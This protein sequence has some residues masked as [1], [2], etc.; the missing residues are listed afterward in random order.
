ML[1]ELLVKYMKLTNKL[2][3]EVARLKEE[4][5]DYKT[6]YEAALV[7]LEDQDNY[8]EGLQKDLDKLERGYNVLIEKKTM[9]NWN[10]LKEQMFNCGE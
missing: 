6:M 3:V 1:N 7:E 2:N 4:V 5:E 10:R 8:I 9:Q